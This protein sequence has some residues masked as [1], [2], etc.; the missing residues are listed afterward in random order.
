MFTYT[1]N[2]RSGDYKTFNTVKPSVILDIAQDIAIRHS[3]TCNYGLEV[4]RGMNFAWLLQGMKLHL[5]RQVE[6]L[7]PITAHTA[8]KNM[9]GTTSE[10]GTLFEQD[11]QIVAKTIA[12]WFLFDGERQRPA[13]IPSEIAEAYGFHDFEDDFFTFKKPELIAAEPLYN[14]RVSNKEIDTNNHLNNQKSAEILMDALPPH[15]LFTDMT[16]FYKKAAY[17]GDTLTLCRADIENG[18]YAQL[19][20]SNGDICVAGTFEIK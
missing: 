19:I 2:T 6:T 7:K 20:N 17:L 4:L 3:D 18:Y 10:R 9:R 11:G 12:N 14:V 13:R 8:V 16:V 15:F 1:Y 5:N